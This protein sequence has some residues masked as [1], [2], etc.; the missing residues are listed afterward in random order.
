MIK[1]TLIGLLLLTIGLISA[2]L[3]SNN[4]CWDKYPTQDQAIQMCEKHDN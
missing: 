2:I 1:F 3:F 4:N